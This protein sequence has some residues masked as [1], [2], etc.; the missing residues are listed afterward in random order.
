MRSAFPGATWPGRKRRPPFHRI[1]DGTAF[2]VGVPSADFAFGFA[3]PSRPENN[4]YIRDILLLPRPN[5]SRIVL[6][7][8]G[9]FERL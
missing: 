6:F 9:Q 5:I 7:V 4:R 1:P 2:S 3:V 8:A